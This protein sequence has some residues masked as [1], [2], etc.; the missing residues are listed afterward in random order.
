MERVGRWT[1]LEEVRRNGRKYCV[2]RCDCG[3]VKEV[4]YRSL[5]LGL[6]LSCGCL[7]VEKERAK[8][9]DLTGRKIGKLTVIGRDA[10]RYGYWLC[11]CECGNRK[12][13]VHRSLR[14]GI[15]QSCGCIQRDG[16]VQTGTKT[17]AGNSAE[18]VRDNKRYRTNFSVIE[19]RELPKN[20]TS[21][22]KG[23]W[24]DK[25]RSMWSAYI[26]VHGK[27]IHL[28]RHYKKE[29]AIKAREAAEKEYFAPMIEK[30]KHEGII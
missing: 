12:S 3:T 21:G 2:C 11:E 16:A 24:W 15:T 23:I 7:R 10:E 26:Q 28:G 5:E 18:R 27:K 20:N 14:D 6:S 8:G 1:V 25:S 17:I 4:Y 22:H 9:G 13:I 29:D 19:S 30:R